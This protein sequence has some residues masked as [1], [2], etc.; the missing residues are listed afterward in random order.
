MKMS[1]S[2]KYVVTTA[3]SMELSFKQAS[4]KE[5]AEYVIWVKFFF[6]IVLPVPL[7]EVLF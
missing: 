5:H 2:S 7:L 4:A 6:L 1:L 3:A